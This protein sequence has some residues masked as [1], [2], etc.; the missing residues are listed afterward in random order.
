MATTLQQQLAKG[1]P[2]IGT[3]C[4]IASPTLIEAAGYAGMDFVIIDNEHGPIPIDGL[5]EY[6]RTA[7]AAGITPLVRVGENNP[8]LIGKALDLG[9]AGVVVPQIDSVDAAR[10]AVA[11]A[12]YSPLGTRGACPCVRSAQYGG[13]PST[14][15]Y[16]QENERTAVVLLVEGPNGMAVL[17]EILAVPGVDALLIGP[18]DLS[19]S[20]GLAG[21][22]DHPLVKAT[23][24]EM[25]AKARARGVAVGV[26]S[27]DY[28]DAREWASLGAQL[29]PFSTDS[30]L[31]FSVCRQTVTAIRGE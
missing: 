6:L 16:A 21:Q 1:R 14:R 18:V 23:M 10:A 22:E 2:L 4:Q 30:M 25:A 11:A 5:A 7:E 12:K 26:F 17:D 27:M 9:A 3:F 15:F 24:R 8:A 29:L 13:I 20:L 19:H 28:A 31:F